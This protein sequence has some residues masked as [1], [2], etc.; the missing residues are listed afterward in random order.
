MKIYN[1]LQK[2]KIMVYIIC[3]LVKNTRILIFSWEFLN[4]YIFKTQ[5][6]FELIK[7]V[8]KIFITLV[9]CFN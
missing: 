6:L 7:S 9:S 1:N 3:I 5:I 4:D 8:F 2:T